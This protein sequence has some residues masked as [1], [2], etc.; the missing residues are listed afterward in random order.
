MSGDTAP[1]AA[2]ALRIVSGDPDPEQVAALVV[3]FSALGS[4]PAPEPRVSAWSG[5]ARAARRS[6]RPGPDSWRLSMRR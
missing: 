3:L 1:P 5:S 4:T 2:P 6:P